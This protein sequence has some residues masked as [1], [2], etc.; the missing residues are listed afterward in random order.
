M[1]KWSGLMV[2]VAL[3]GGGSARAAM[4]GL[5][6]SLVSDAGAAVD[7]AS[8]VVGDSSDAGTDD[9]A[10]AKTCPIAEPAVGDPCDLRMECEYGDDPHIE[11]NRQYTCSS[12]HFQILREADAGCPTVLAAG[13]PPTRASLIAGAA[14]ATTG[15]QCTYA[16]GDCQCGMSAADGSSAWFCLPENTSVGSDAACP[17]PRPRLGTSCSLQSAVYCS[18]ESNCT[19]QSCN[20]CGEWVLGYIPCGHAPPP[21]MMEGGTAALLMDGGA[22]GGGDSSVD[23]SFRGDGA[24]AGSG[25]V[26]NSGGCGCGVADQRLGAGGGAGLILGIALLA[27]RRRSEVSRRSAA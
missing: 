1:R 14:C 11:C 26:G 23:A 8:D 19:F 12:G 21:L 4:N 17:V 24:T 2:I 25:A 6:G 5:D 27:R 20:P 7:A 3:A 10:C 13:C 9:D 22:E 15:L 18:Y 16:E